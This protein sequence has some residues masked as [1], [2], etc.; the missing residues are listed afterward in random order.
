M[1]II[2]FYRMICRW[3]K[4]ALKSIVNIANNEMFNLMLISEQKCTFLVNF[5][6]GDELCNLVAANAIEY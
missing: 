5:H 2:F 3:K 1:V 6:K 4:S